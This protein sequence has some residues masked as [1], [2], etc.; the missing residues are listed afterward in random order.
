MFMAQQVRAVLAA[1]GG[2]HNTRQVALICSCVV[3]TLVT[4]RIS[5][6]NECTQLVLKY[7][8]SVKP[9]ATAACMTQAVVV[10]VIW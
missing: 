9:K 4:E 2:L 3:Y 7:S 6:A 8:K 5:D 10:S 1:E